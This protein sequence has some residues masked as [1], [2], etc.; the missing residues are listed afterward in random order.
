MIL[1]LYRPVKII[2]NIVKVDSTKCYFQYL[3]LRSYFLHAVIFD[4]SFIFL[5]ALQIQKKD[6]KKKGELVLSIKMLGW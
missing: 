5:Y 4:H 1:F 3:I 6:I 2:L